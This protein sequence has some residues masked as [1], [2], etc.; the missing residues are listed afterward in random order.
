MTRSDEK[1]HFNQFYAGLIIGFGCGFLIAAS[2]FI[3]LFKT[4][5][6]Q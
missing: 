3:G 1:A 2:L 5:V 6:L 4:G